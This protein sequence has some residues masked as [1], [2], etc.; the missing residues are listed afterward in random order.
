MLSDPPR[1]EKGEVTP[2]NHPQISDDDLIIRRI[3]EQQIVPD[4]KAPSGRKVSSIAFNPSTEG[5][6]SVSVD[7]D[8]SIAEAGLDPKVFVTSPR[9]I[10]SISLTASQFRSKSLMVGYDPLTE[11]PH[12]GGVWGSFT[13][14]VK[15]ALIKDA[16]WFV[17]IPNVDLST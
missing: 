11:N 3:S 2:H 17:Q 16:Q 5:S 15:N 8:K 7:L 9:W 1:D 4:E 12:H 6:K 10:G 14:S 13:K